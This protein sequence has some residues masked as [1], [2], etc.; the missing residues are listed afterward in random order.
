MSNITVR[1]TPRNRISI[2]TQQKGVVRV[3]STGLTGA[4]VGA[5][6]K[7]ADLD[8]V[9]ATSVDN[10]ETI[11]YDSQKEKFVVKELPVLNGGEF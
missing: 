5:I 7:F 4:G 2:N 11:V 3:G 1:T 6:R 10:N 9:D 8:D